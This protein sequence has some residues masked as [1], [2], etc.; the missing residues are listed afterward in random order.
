MNEFVTA[1]K[2]RSV[3]A[4][5]ISNKN[6]TI[7]NIRVG[8]TIEIP[9]LLPGTDFYVVERMDNI[10][11]GYIFDRKTLTEDTY[12]PADSGI[13]LVRDGGNIAPD[14]KIKADADAEV[15]VYNKDVTVNFVKVDATDMETPLPKAQFTLKN[16]DPEGNGSYVSG[17]GAV[18]KTS[19]E[20]NAKGNTFIAGIKNGYYEISETS[21]PAGYVLVDDGKFFIRVQNG[22][23]TLLTKDINKQVKEWSERTLT[24]QDKLQFNSGTLTFTVGNTPGVALPSTG[25]PG[26]NLYYLFGIMLT[27][28]AG[29]GLVL[30][31]RRR[32]L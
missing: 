31:K 28:F 29:A 12:D 32:V 25:G 27:A 7:G 21:V 16:L 11:D 23:V 13:F 15:T 19:V 8:Y 17:T 5:E 18:D 30:R 9:G 3:T 22:S 26:T 4:H 2:S 20:T 6:G 14:G 1:S 10:P 24:D